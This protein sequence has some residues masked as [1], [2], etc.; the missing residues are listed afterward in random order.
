METFLIKA[1]QLIIALALLVIIHEFGHFIFARIFGIKVEKFYMFFDPYFSLFKWKPKQ[2]PGADPNKTSWRDTEYGIGWIPLGG[3]CKIAGMIDESLDTEQMK[4]EPKPWE[5]R[6]KPAWQ[7]LLVMLGGV[8]FNFILAILIYAGIAM[9]WGAQYIPFDAAT[10]GF[11]FSPAAQSVGFRNG[12]IPY[13]ADGELLDASK[14]D[15]PYRMADADV[16][17]VIR[18]HKDTVNIN[19]PDDFL[20]RLNDDKGFLAYRVPVYVERLVP[21]EAAAKAGLEPGDHLIAIDTIPTPSFTEFAEALLAYADKPV[22]ITLVRNGK[23]MK[24]NVT[25]NSHGKLGFNLRPITSIY[26]PVTVEYNFFESFPK[27]WEIGTTTLSNYVGSMKHVFSREGAESLGGFGAIGNMF[28]ERWNWLSFWEITA[29]LSVALAF[30]NII[31]IP[32]L[33]GGHVMFLFWE[34]ITGKQAPEK[35]MIA[36]QYVG[37]IFLLMLLLYANGNDIFR[38]FFK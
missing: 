24:L 12:D 13:M 17:T 4:Q 5:F 38:A 9:H 30:M 26:E 29:F 20:L 36:A 27:G 31:P 1:L 18:N 16:V 25:P 6:T 32:G 11:D 23:T 35:V 3:Y 10:E 14:S 8:V 33:D 22:D 37:M 21:G 7:R 15:Y 34:M 28:P 2:K 19:I